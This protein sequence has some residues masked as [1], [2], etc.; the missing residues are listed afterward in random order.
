M[1]L[2]L[3][4]AC[5]TDDSGSA[6]HV[7]TSGEFTDCDPIA[8]DYCAA[9]FPSTFY[10]REDTTTPT[11]WRVHLG[12]TTIPA[13]DQDEI[14]YQPDPAL[15]NELDGFSPM[16]PILTY[17][18]NL[19]GAELPDQ[20]HIEDSLADDAPIALVDWDTGERMPYFAELDY[21]GQ[22]YDG[23]EM[24]FVRPVVPLRNGHRYIVAIRG[25]T[26]TSGAVVAA[27]EGYAALR[28]G[29]ATED[30]DLEGRRDEYEELYTKLEAQG[31]TRGDTQLAWDFVVKSTDAVA[32]RALWMRDDARD[33]AEADGVPYTLDS[34]EENPDEHTRWRVYG[35]MTVPLYTET[36]DP[37]TLLT[38]D[39]DGMPYMNGSV[40]RPFTIIVPNSVVD[41][42]VPAPMIQY[43]H[44]LLGDQDEV[45]GGYLA[46]EADR[47]GYVLFAV[48]W[49]GMAEDDY[50]GVVE[51]VLNDLSTFGAVPE[52]E[53]QGYTEFMDAAYLMLLEMPSD[54]QFT[55]DGGGSLLDPSRLYYYGNSQGG[56]LGGAYMALTQDVTLGTLGV[57][58]MPYSLLLSRSAD[59][60]AYFM[61]FETVYDDQRD[62]AFWM[63]LMQQ[64]WDPG[65]GGGF[66]RQ[67]N[68][69]PL[70]DTPA[71]TILIQD[72]RGDAQVTN[73][74]AHN[75]ARAYG[76]VQV[77]EPLRDIYGVSTEADGWTGSAIT[78]FSFGAPEEPATNTP[79]DDETDTH[80][81]ARRAW[82]AQEQMFHFFETGG[83]VVNYCQGQCTCETGAC[84]DPAAGD[85]GG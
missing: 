56:I 24:L 5:G 53:L 63:A 60:S 57:P 70:A 9:P 18:P 84:D 2:H 78:E 54:P 64:L 45:E 81:D 20:D 7:P 19:S 42:G 75:M 80:E 51:I 44:G 58:G 10:L 73:L 27:S 39:A 16:G 83:E 85:T 72:A 34:V 8:P 55:V 33:R 14:A 17:F 26:D 1:L 13:T 48:N 52:R 25:L 49:T 43:G 59:F 82:A 15:W 37:P 30:W 36:D 21:S 35:T 47:H 46:E 3:L 40:E 50:N 12:A 68:E 69:E 62:I 28:D 31:W 22:H 4:V 66:G 29:T 71:K 65:E 11:G 23:Y 6:L 61:L 77:G 38:R 76:A 74:G 32:K 41:A 79:P 67:M